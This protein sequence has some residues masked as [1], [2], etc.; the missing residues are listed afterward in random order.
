MRKIYDALEMNAKGIV[1]Q[2]KMRTKNP[3]GEQ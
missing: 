1:G 2:G 3:G